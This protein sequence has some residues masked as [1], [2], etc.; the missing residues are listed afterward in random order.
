MGRPTKYKDTLCDTVINLMSQGASKTEV[1]AEIDIDFDTL[2]DWCN[3][4]SERYNK[5]FSDAIKKG[6]RLS[7]AW[8]ERKGRENLGDPKFSY[9][10]WFMNM[11]NRFRKADEKWADKIDVEQSGTVAVEILTFTQSTKADEDT[12]SL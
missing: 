8:W 6:T 12:N 7:Q 4:T 2:C 9:T 11:K 5:E 10:G 1:C 3:S